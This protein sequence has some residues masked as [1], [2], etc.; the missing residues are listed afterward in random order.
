MNQSFSNPKYLG[1]WKWYVEERETSVSEDEILTIEYF[2]NFTPWLKW[3]RILSSASSCVQYSLGSISADW[4][5]TLTHA[6]SSSIWQS[7]KY[8][9]LLSEKSLMVHWLRNCWK[10]TLFEE[11]HQNLSISTG[12]GWLFNWN[13]TSKTHEINEYHLI[14]AWAMNTFFW[15]E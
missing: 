7:P 12:N 5:K 11:R 9:T 8:T 15:F 14:F 3:N 10:E 2:S 1:C 4:R 13:F 6:E